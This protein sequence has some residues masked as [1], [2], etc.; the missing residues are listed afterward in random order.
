MPI[1]MM[2]MASISNNGNLGRR[3]VGKDGQA[4]RMD[5]LND[6]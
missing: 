4:A 6:D 3:S 2:A 5:L 1:E